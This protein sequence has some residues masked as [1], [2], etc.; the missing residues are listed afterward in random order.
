MDSLYAGKIMITPKMTALTKQYEALR[1]E[2]YLDSKDIPTIGYGHKILP[3]E[4]FS[5]GITQQEADAIFTRDYSDAEDA[6]R[7]LVKVFDTLN[8]VR[9]AVVVDLI[10]NL[11]AHGFSEF[12]NTIAAINRL[13]FVQARNEMIDSDWYGEVK[14]RAVNDC[15]LILRGTWG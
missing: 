13:D 6:A 11:G 15:L 8:E 14:T 2:E 3:G 4:D 12:H 1:L 10:F 9:Q 5:G 7:K